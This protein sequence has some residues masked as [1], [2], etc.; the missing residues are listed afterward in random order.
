MKEGEYI[1]VHLNSFNL[2][3]SQLASMD[4]KIEEDEKFI[5]LICSFPE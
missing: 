5:I 1:I 4:V 3:L 2:I